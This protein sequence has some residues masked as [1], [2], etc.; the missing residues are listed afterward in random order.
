MKCKP[1]EAR[2]ERILILKF[3]LLTVYPCYGKSKL[4]DLCA[5]WHHTTC[6]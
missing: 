4:D 1:H 2:D 3:R 5:N 6:L